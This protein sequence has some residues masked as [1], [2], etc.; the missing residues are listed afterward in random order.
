MIHTQWQNA[1]L[2]DFIDWIDN[3][4]KDD[5]KN[6]SEKFKE[7]EEKFKSEFKNHTGNDFTTT[8]PLMNVIE[9]P[10]NYKIEIAAPGLSKESFKITLSNNYLLISADLEPTLAADEK[11]N[12]KEFDYRKFERRFRLPENADTEHIDAKYENGLLEVWIQKK[13]KQEIKIQVS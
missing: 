4:F 3:F 10:Q 13:F 5:F 9:S 7:F 11:F 1:P 2:K 8:S 6:W 12:Q